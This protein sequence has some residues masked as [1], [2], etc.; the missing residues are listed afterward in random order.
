ME[1][2]S[3]KNIV[4]EKPSSV[5]EKIPSLKINEMYQSIQGEGAYTGFP[6]VFIRTTGCNLRCS[7]CDSEYS[8]YEGEHKTFEDITTYVKKFPNSIV[9]LTGGEPLLQKH[10]IELMQHLIELDKTVL[11]ETSGSKSIVNV[12]AQVHIIL[13]LKAPGSGEVKKNF[14]DNL[15]FLKK[16]DDLKFIITNREDFRWAS[17]VVQDYKLYDKLLSPPIVQTAFGQLEN[18]RLAQWVNES[19]I[20]FRLGIQMHKYIYDPQARGV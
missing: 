6:C 2:T 7:W 9:E 16:T 12:P 11:L 1:L 8:F 15:N 14:F 3:K 19:N 5:T 4:M 17:Q 13:D 18:Q 10:A 20:L